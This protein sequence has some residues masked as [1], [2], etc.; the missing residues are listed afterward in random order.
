MNI[1]YQ[2]DGVVPRFSATWDSTSTPF[3]VAQSA[4]S[5]PRDPRCWHR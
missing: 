4:G 1:D 3:V 5:L 2:G